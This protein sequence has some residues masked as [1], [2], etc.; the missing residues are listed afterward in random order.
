[1]ERAFLFMLFGRKQEA[2]ITILNNKHRLES[3]WGINKV[4]WEDKPSERRR[5]IKMAFN[6]S[7]AASG[8][9]YTTKF[10]AKNISFHGD[11][12]ERKV[13]SSKGFFVMQ[14]ALP[15][16]IAA[17][18]IIFNILLLPSTRRTFSL[19]IPSS[20]LVSCHCWKQ[21]RLQSVSS[22]V[23]CYENGFSLSHRG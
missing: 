3:C 19:Q 22:D 23:D 17:Y 1:M 2:V 13:I 11:F 4:S 16:P 10:S 15:T 7:S 5:W 20:F 14:N 18:E 12:S 21:I 9:F 8:N 6:S